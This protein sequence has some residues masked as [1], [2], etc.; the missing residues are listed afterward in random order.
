MLVCWAAP[1]VNRSSYKL[2]FHSGVGV[3]RLWTL[4]SSER[5]PQLGRSEQNK[6]RDEVHSAKLRENLGPKSAREAGVCD[7][8]VPLLFMIATG[9]LHSLRCLP[10]LFLLLKGTPTA[11]SSV[12][13]TSRD[14]TQLPSSIA[15][16]SL[17]VQSP[18]QTIPSKLG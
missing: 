1:F 13:C 3:P 17:P 14:G 11:C 10:L 9:M 16:T 18:Y 12:A 15:R 4:Q 6:D 5:C 7:C 2:G 8:P